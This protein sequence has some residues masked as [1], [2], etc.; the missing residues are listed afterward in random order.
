MTTSIESTERA[1]RSTTTFLSFWD[2]ALSNLTEG[3]FRKRVL[4][5]DEARQKIDAAR[6][7]GRLICVA[8][9]DLRAPYCERERA[10]HEQLC[11]AL[12]G[13]VELRLQDFIGPTC[14]NPLCI[15]EVGQ[16]AQL[17][18]VDCRYSLERAPVAVKSKVGLGSDG[19]V[20][21]RARKAEDL[22][23]MA[24]VPDSIRFHLFERVDLGSECDGA[25]S[26]GEP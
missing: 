20:G 26:G 3:T 1:T 6:A 2:V 19:A 23:R 21:R 10:Q 7:A 24:V 12:R 5:V 8:K 13:L 9:D 4:T 17:L 11:E 16:H 15:A 25:A 14:V 22:L 18:V